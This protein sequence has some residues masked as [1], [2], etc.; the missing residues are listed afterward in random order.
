LGSGA[1]KPEIGK[2]KKIKDGGGGG[3]DGFDDNTPKLGSN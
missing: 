1:G 3:W 2:R